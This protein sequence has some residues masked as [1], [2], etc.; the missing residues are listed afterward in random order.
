MTNDEQYDRTE[1]GTFYN[2]YKEV[3]QLQLQKN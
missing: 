1:W 2:G 3:G